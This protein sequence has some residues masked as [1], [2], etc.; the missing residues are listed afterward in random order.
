VPGI[1]AAWVK[2]FMI[3]ES[4]GDLLTANV[5]ALVNPVNTVGVMGRGLA[6]QFKQA[7]PAN[8]RA[9]QAACRN[10]EV[11]IRKMFVTRTDLSCPRFI[12]NF[13]TKR[14]WR[15]ASRLEDIH[16]GLEDL[17]AVVER[18]HIRSLAVPPLGFGLG[19]LLWEEVYPLIL[20]AFT[21]LPAVEVHLYVPEQQEKDKNPAP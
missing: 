2:R 14:H 8:F 1:R 21:V 5:E 12:I 17:T 13:P 4:K 7:F 18:E 11:A 19:G 20:Q 15:E 10:G 9:Y 16:L 3:I 6:L